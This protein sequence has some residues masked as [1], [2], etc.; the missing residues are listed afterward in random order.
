MH[1]DPG[2]PGLIPRSV[3]CMSSD[4]ADTVMTNLFCSIDNC[5][6]YSNDINS[7]NDNNNDNY[8]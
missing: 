1:C 6:N 3:T 5:N 4:L 7:D 2:H 8:V